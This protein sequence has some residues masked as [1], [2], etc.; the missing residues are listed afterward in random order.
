VSY[1]DQTGLFAA[2]THDGGMRGSTVLLVGEHSDAMQVIK[3]AC[4][5]AVGAEALRNDII[6]QVHD[7]ELG[8]E[9]VMLRTQSGLDPFN[10]LPVRDWPTGLPHSGCTLATS[11]STDR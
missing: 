10:V 3:H 9:T 2:L 1:R 7:V 5:A 8:D 11:R 6:R 4:N